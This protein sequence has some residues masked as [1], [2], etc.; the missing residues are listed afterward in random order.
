MNTAV[1][2]PSGGRAHTL[3]AA[4]VV[5]ALALLVATLAASAA[6]PPAGKGGTHTAGAYDAPSA[7]YSS[8]VDGGTAVKLTQGAG[9]S[10]H[11]D[12]TPHAR[13]GAVVFASTAPAGDGSTDAELYLRS[14]DGSVTQLTDTPA[15][16]ANPELSPDGAWVAYDDGGGSHGKGG[17]STG[18][19]DDGEDDAC[20]GHEE[21]GLLAVSET[22]A[23]A[24]VWV[25]DLATRTPTRVT[26]SPE[27]AGR[28]VDPTWSPDG[29]KIAYTVGA[30]RESHI[31]VVELA[32]VDGVP[33]PGAAADVTTPGYHHSKPA[34][35]PVDEDV[36]AYMRSTG[37][38]ADV[39]TLDRSTVPP[40]YR[41]LTPTET[42][43]EVAPAWSPDGSSIAY[44][45][46]G[47]EGAAVWVMGA[48]GSSPRP[49][50]VPDGWSD[51]HPSFSDGG[52]VVFESTRG[53]RPAAD[54]SVVLGS[55][56]STTTL[57]GRV[58]LSASLANFGPRTARDLTLAL[59]L[60][61]GLS[62]VS[63]S[64]S[65]PTAAASVTVADGVVRLALPEL[66]RTTDGTAGPELDVVVTAARAGT[67]TSTAT[68][69]L[70]DV[71]NLFD[72][73]PGNNTASVAT[74]VTTPTTTA[75][76]P[77]APPAAAP[78]PAPPARP[79]P[80]PPAPASKCTITGTP[81]ADVL[82]GTAAAD[83]VCGLAGS[84]TILGLAGNDTLLGGPGADMLLG[85]A[86][87]DVVN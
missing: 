70:A 69:S 36:I 81:R 27:T 47:G 66:A 3:G 57:G 51:R 35:H 44:Q 43:G 84:D 16:E 7:V 52:T 10:Q 75:A 53:A 1:T 46:V 37:E 63:A 28:A 41:L 62:F 58:T 49:V 26:S 80:A 33:V 20:G 32:F 77:A 87:N 74:A 40:T 14:A 23:G 65:P 83:V 29:T 42:V 45:R 72:P 76:A 22:L 73:A 86:G 61:D 15:H 71:P 54:A 64:V 82:V 21:P 30:S 38:R 31:E 13:G 55:D 8:G 78:R 59:D 56:P 79:A 60:G 25:L 85:G 5:A 24:Q 34:W 9:Y 12:S 18:D 11:F 68:V 6:G 50:T 4:L 67:W 19:H 2:N 39:W 48:D 17:C